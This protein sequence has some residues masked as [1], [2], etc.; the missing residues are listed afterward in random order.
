MVGPLGS[1]EFSAP[2][3]QW[4]PLRPVARGLAVGVLM[5]GL[6]GCA[7][8]H[9]APLSKP[10][11]SVQMGLTDAQ[12]ELRV[13]ADALRRTPWDGADAAPAQASGTGFSV[14]QIFGML[15]DGLPSGEPAQPQDPSGDTAPQPALSTVAERY[16]ASIETVAPGPEARD[17]A[18]LRDMV[19][20]TTLT[21][22]FVSAACKVVADHRIAGLPAGDDRS[23][24]IRNDYVLIT[25]M[26]A[27]LQAQMATFDEVAGALSGT[28]TAPDPLMAQAL[29]QWR[30]E[31]DALAVLKRSIG[32]SPL[33]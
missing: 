6:G 22:R 27:Q 18:V 23:E 10:V 9:I 31:V 24:D 12:I 13:Q 4:V 26:L 17:Q 14:G 7:A 16:L 5:A 25:D 2:Q 33:S 21:R 30:G 29:T 15:V 8:G 19:R 3:G 11:Q 1:Q 28:E 20:R 32:A